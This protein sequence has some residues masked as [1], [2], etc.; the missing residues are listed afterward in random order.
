MTRLIVTLE[1]ILGV[2]LL[3]AVTKLV[4]MGYFS[5]VSHKIQPGQTS[6][7]CQNCATLIIWKANYRPRS[8]P[9]CGEDAFVLTKVKK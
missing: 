4:S 5:M 8:C 3:W 6:Y 1:A 9:Y 2:G 7:T